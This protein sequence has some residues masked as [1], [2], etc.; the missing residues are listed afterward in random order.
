MVSATSRFR[1][2]SRVLLLGCLV[3][4]IFSGPHGCSTGN[5]SKNVPRLRGVWMQAR[6]INTPEKADDMLARIEA[7]HFNAVFVNVFVNG[8]AYY[9]STL[10]EKQPDLAPDY[11][12]LAYVIEQAHRRGIAVHT[13]LVAGPVGDHGEPG[14]ILTQHPDWP[15]VGPDGWQSFWLN[16][17]RQDVRQFIG[18][19]VLEIVKNYDVD[20]VHFDY[21][22]Y[23]G[24]QWGFDP[25]SAE[26]FAQKYGID[27][28][29]L[30][31]SGL[32]AYATFKSNPLAGVDTAQVLA[33]F[34]NGRPAVLL[35]SYG[36][37]KAVL[38]NW[39]AN[40]RQVAASSEI[41][42]RS[43]DYLSDENGDVYILRSETNAEKYGFG[44]FDEGV[45]WIKDLGRL[46][47][48]ITEADLAALDVDGVL[49]MP[50]VYLITSQVASDLADFVRR[51]GG[52]IFIDGP[53][54]SIGDENIQAITG[55]RAR[56]RYFEETGLLI[57]TGQHDIIP[58]S[59]QELEL[60]DYQ[61]LDAQWK[62]FR[63]QGINKLLQEV[64]QR[65]KQEA[66]DVLITISVGADQKALAEQVL[67][68]WQAWLEGEYVDLIIPR[69]YV[70][71][72]ES[73]K[74][75]IADWQQ[76]MESSSRVILGL[77]AYTGS[78]GENILKPPARVLS[79]I[80]LAC[81]SG[82]DGVVLFDIEHVGDNVLEPLATGPFSSP[83]A[84][85]N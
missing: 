75:I 18:D 44:N 83:V 69:A 5:Y 65:T 43:I 11:D 47:I 14:P 35:N 10:L 66:P 28:D 76:T 13:W 32:P 23:P 33:A 42:H 39:D 55:M 71:Q 62:T 72:D 45:A 31:Y 79:E 15:M 53:T 60:E 12:P 27:L 3:L 37:G 36:A 41:L 17:T 58:N 52:V 34:G 82:S 85:S 81:A 19:L 2:L 1:R 70:D 80:D 20:G 59:N 38:L 56:G 84:N 29:I 64:Y 48:E 61:A 40:E 22:R 6:S 68:D 78:Y 25:Y 7:G 46:P 49:V 9:E 4:G 77:K 26:A 24:P 54:P 16:Y 67:L 63:K 73:L 50:N 51:G 74:P 57:A 30:R 8:H 21:T